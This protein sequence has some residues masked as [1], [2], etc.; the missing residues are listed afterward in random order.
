MTSSKTAECLF[1]DIFDASALL[2]ERQALLT[3]A[4][5]NTCVLRV[6]N[7]GHHERF[8]TKKMTFTACIAIAAVVYLGVFLFTCCRF[9]RTAVE[10]SGL[11]AC[12]CPCIE[13]GLYN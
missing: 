3:F 7:N 5:T 4:L 8:P 6:S 2:G 9:G 10:W 12:Y 13:Q 1:Y 11:F